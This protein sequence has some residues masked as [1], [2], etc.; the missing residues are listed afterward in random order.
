MELGGD[1][2]NIY[3][4]NL[5]FVE[6]KKGLMCYYLFNYQDTVVKYLF[7]ILFSCIIGVT[8]CY[9]RCEDSANT[10][11]ARKKERTGTAGGKWARVLLPREWQDIMPEGRSTSVITSVIRSR[12]GTH[13][14]S[15]PELSDSPLESDE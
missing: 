9:S 8:R 13:S 15:L 5:T 10:E 11:V 6:S 4:F 7:L 1:E 3:V 14:E 12:R 2:D